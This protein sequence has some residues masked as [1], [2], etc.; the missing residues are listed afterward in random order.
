MVSA[1]EIMLTVRLTKQF[2]KRL[3]KAAKRL[4]KSKTALARE[5][6]VERM[7]ELEALY[8]PQGRRSKRQ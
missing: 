2:E 5:A 3:E 1:G 7:G 6:V 4:G 8:L